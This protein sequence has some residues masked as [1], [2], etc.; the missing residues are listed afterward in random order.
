MKEEWLNI[1]RSLASSV[2]ITHMTDCHRSL[3]TSYLLLIEDLCHETITLNSM[4]I[5][6][7]IDSHYTTTLLTSVLK[8]VQA[9]ISKACSILNTIY[10]K[11]TTLMV[12]F[13]ISITILTSTHSYSPLK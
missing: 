4:K 8:G 5:T 1:L 6:M 11:H 12:E 7:R 3:K 13:V 2:A 10:S 9:I